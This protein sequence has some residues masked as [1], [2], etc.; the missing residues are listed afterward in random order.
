[1]CI[2]DSSCSG[3]TLTNEAGSA[4]TADELAVDGDLFLRAATVTGE[5]RLLGA[6]IGGQLACSGATLTNEAGPALYADGLTVDGDL[7]L[8]AATVTSEVRLLG[9]HIG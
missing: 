3:A 4:L 2:R 8:P 7:F 9:A 5:V 6:H 1:M